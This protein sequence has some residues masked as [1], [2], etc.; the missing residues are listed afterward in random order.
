MKITRII[1]AALVVF[2]LAGATFGQQGKREGQ[3]RKPA[4]T[5]PTQY[6]VSAKAGAVNIA[7]GDVAYKRGEDDWDLLIAGDDLRSGAV[8][9]TGATGR[10]EILLNPGSYLRVSEHTELVFVDTSLDNLKIEILKGS[11]IIE[12]A[13]ADWES[14]PIASIITPHSEFRIVRGGLYR[15][16]VAAGRTVAAVRKGKLLVPQPSAKHVKG[17]EWV[18]V[19]NG[20]SRTMVPAIAVKEGRQIVIESGQTNIVAF[21][22]K[23]EDSFDLWSKDRARTLIAANKRLANQVFANGAIA[24]RMYI[25]RW[26]TGSGFWIYNA[27]LGCWT[28]L[29]GYY[30]YSSPYGWGYPYCHNPYY[31]Y[32]G[33]GGSTGGTGG[34]VSR[35][36]GSSGGWTGG[37]GGTITRGG[38]NTGGWTG[39]SGGTITRGG[40]SGSGSSSSSSGGSSGG[41]ARSLPP[42]S[43]TGDRGRVVRDN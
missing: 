4:L 16:D 31:G 42:S 11:A 34:G 6:T 22:R 2:T 20:Q 17:E 3:S 27:Y 7:D 26:D 29:P 43:S 40:S 24:R 36:G 14:G 39:G 35:D 9:K 19:S 23:A 5:D 12:V 37:S 33:G 13:V 28:F 1:L 18:A 41:G 8:V 32:P 25:S 38:G 15:F 10:A 30:G 21:D